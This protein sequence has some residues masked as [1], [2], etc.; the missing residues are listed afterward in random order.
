MGLVAWMDT[1]L[2]QQRRV[3]DIVNLFRDQGTI[4]DLGIGQIRDA[5]GD[6]LFPGSS[7]IQT[8]A[9]YLLLVP[10]AFQ[11]AAD[12]QT[13]SRKPLLT[14]AE[15][16]ERSTLLAIRDDP[17]FAEGLIG[18]RAGKNV[19]TL[20][21][22]IYWTALRTYGILELPLNRAQIAP[23]PRRADESTELAERRAGPW[24]ATLPPRPER[25][26][27]QVPG[28]LELSAEEAAWLQERIVLSV[29]ESLLGTL[30]RSVDPD[31]VYETATPW[32]ALRSRAI[33]AQ[34]RILLD[35]AELFSRT[36]HGAAWLYNVLL[37]EA[38]AKHKFTPAFGEV[39]VAHY[40]KKFDEWATEMA[41]LRP[42]VRR[43]DLRAF[44]R[45]V[46]PASSRIGWPTKQFVEHWIRAVQDG[47]A[48]DAMDD[49]GLRGLVH[50]RESAKK[51]PLAMLGNSR[52]LARWTGSS[53]TTLLTYR[54][55]NVTRVLADI[56]EGLDRAGT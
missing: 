42:Q 49:D 9:R 52:R 39:G 37:A 40:R 29:P 43:W 26:P 23:M 48:L 32:D 10:W 8:R 36:M 17:L 27:Y 44:W 51:G 35:H 55:P 33:P 5:L 30:A 22:Q 46:G 6:L 19:R 18:R 13:S 34:Q 21:S 15:E 1:S 12:P 24:V 28:G 16:Y 50:Q 4:D 41:L 14:R 20:P 11:L 38:F 56:R 53:G 2:E 31:I 47:S 54:W 45:A 7:T 25:F 3:R